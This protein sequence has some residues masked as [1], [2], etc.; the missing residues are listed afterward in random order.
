MRKQL[1]FTVFASALVAALIVAIA[2][3]GSRRILRD[4]HRQ[5]RIRRLGRYRRLGPLHQQLGQSPMVARLS[6]PVSR[7]TASG[8][9]W[10]ISAGSGGRGSQR[11]GGPTPTADG[12]EPP[13]AGPGSPTSPGAMSPTTTAVGRCAISVGSG[14]PA[15][16]TRP[17]TSS[18]SAAAVTSDGTRGHRAAGATPPAAT[19]M[20]IRTAIET[21]GTMRATRPT[22]TGTTRLR[23]TSP[24]TRSRHS[25]ASRGRVEDHALRRPRP[26]SGGAAESRWPET[27]GLTADGHHERPDNHHRTAGG[28]YEEHRRPRL[29]HRCAALSSA[30]LE[31]RQPQVRARAPVSVTSTAGRDTGR[32]LPTD[33]RTEYGERARSPSRSVIRDSDAV[34][35][36][37]DRTGRGAVG[38]RTPT[39]FVSL[40]QRPQP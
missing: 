5:R 12:C 25:V 13:S 17:P 18:G 20:D 19:A 6:T 7:A 27:P 8:C 15:T 16:P 33:R 23:T 2:A 26:R 22:S 14:S 29:H 37:P 36:H 40:P 9:G 24:T 38:S 32:D 34:I 30:A 1:K 28:R 31:R 4:P 11:A 10:D 39:S 21:V 35:D 3:S